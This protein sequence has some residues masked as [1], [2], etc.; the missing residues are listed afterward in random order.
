MAETTSTAELRRELAELRARLAAVETSLAPLSAL[1]QLLVRLAAA[2]A[3]EGDPPGAEY[4]LRVL[5][6][7]S[8]RDA[9]RR[10]DL[11]LA[12]TL[13]AAA[14]DPAL[15][16]ERARELLA[17]AASE[18]ETLDVLADPTA[19]ARIEHAEAEI[20]SGDLGTIDD[21][22]A[23]WERYRGDDHE[24]IGRQV[25]EIDVVPV[26]APEEAAVKEP[27]PEAHPANERTSAPEGA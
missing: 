16:L 9:S 22:S 7:A 14:R 3:S 6:G 8:A 2:P 23:D 13:D 15:P 12:D 17:T 18:L 21:L 5:A 26:P 24:G 27:S 20:E 1:R 10:P 25:R 19:L 4:R 11:H